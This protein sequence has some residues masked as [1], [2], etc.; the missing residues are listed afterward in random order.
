MTKR[1]VRTGLLSLF[2]LLVP[3]ASLMAQQRIAVDVT[4]RQLQNKRVLRTERQIFFSNNGNTVVH[5][6]HPQEYVVVSNRLG[7]M[8]I[9]QPSANEVMI[10]Q[11]REAVAQME[12]FLFFVSG[13]CSDL[14]LT[15]LGFMRKSLKKDGE[16]LVAT[17]EP[18][19]PEDKIYSKVVV[20]TQDR[21]PI[22]SAFYGT[23]GKVLKKYYY[24]HYSNLT[25]YTFPTRITQIS[26]GSH[27]DSTIV[28]EEYGNIRTSDFGKEAMFDYSVPADARRVTPFDD[29]RKRKK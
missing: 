16:R 11:D 14:N 2:F 21:K 22:Y 10:M 15:K 4:T 1:T 24:S 19:M 18:T 26:F 23:D 12:T 27:G 17:Y 28:R 9:Y 29:K 7:E 13:D 6:T 8:Q 5:Y 20:V 3:S 25:S